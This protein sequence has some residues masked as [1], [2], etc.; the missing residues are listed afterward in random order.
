MTQS[1]V[2]IQ[3]TLLHPQIPAPAFFRRKIRV[4][5]DGI[6][7]IQGGRPETGAETGFE[8]DSLPGEFVGPALIVIPGQIVVVIRLKITSCEFIGQNG[9]NPALYPRHKPGCCQEKD[10][11][12]GLTPAARYVIVKCRLTIKRFLPMESAQLAKI[13]KT[14][15][16]PTRIMKRLK[17]F[18]NAL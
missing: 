6:K 4:P 8:P 10:S 1:Q 18:V 11:V 14:L 3:K 2:I 15:G 7:F 13:F 17:Q 5:I 16:H 12:S 9:F